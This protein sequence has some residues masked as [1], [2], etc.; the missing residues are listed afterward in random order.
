MVLDQGAIVA[1]GP[2]HELVALA[3]SRLAS[4]W[5]AQLGLDDDAVPQNA[6]RSS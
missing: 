1:A 5:A 2:W 4:L 6:L 3:D